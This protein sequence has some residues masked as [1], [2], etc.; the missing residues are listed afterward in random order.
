ML[1]EVQME[2]RWVILLMSKNLMGCRLL[3]IDVPIKYSAINL[4][5]LLLVVVLSMQQDYVFLANNNM[6]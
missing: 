5:Q 2:G 3:Y 6:I 1:H 4:D